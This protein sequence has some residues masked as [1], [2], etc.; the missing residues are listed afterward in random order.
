M[1]TR[2][3][4]P[5]CRVDCFEP[6]KLPRRLCPVFTIEG[7]D[8]LLE[9]PKLAAVPQRVLRDLAVSLSGQQAEVDDARDFLFRGC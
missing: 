1:D 3:V 7:T 8:C 2:V 5:L 6:V 9:T 4:I